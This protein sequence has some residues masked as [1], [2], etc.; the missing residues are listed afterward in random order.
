MRYGTGGYA[1]ENQNRASRGE[2]TAGS[3]QCCCDVGADVPMVHARQVEEG[4]ALM[5]AISHLIFAVAVVVVAVMC[6]LWFLRVVI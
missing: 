4:Q 2:D 6:A 1:H 3:S 5:R